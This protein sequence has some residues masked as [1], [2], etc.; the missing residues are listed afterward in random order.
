MNYRLAHP[1][2]SRR[3]KKYLVVAKVPE[4][5]FNNII[6]VFYLFLGFWDIFFQSF[7]YCAQIH[8][9]IS[10]VR[11]VLIVLGSDVKQSGMDEAQGWVSLIFFSLS[12]CLW[13]F[14]LSGFSLSLGS[15]P[16][17]YLAL[18]PFSLVS[19][20]SLWSSPSLSFLFSHSR[21]LALSGCSPSPAQTH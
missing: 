16:S 10:D 6:Y 9:P 15:T 18:P 2:Q 5:V 8:I 12:R 14:F 4:H 19:L 11:F 7:S 1:A 13:S 21:S 3:F 17:L 20:F